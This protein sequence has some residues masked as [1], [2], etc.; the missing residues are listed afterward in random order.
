MLHFNL[1]VFVSVHSSRDIQSDVS[2]C[3]F[4][5]RLKARAG[6]ISVVCARVCV[7]VCGVCV[8][9]ERVYVCGERDGK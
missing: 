4:I 8:C 5:Q 7:C 9:V 6:R 1:S 3:H 2:L